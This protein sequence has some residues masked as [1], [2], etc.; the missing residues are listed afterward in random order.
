M[1]QTSGECITDVLTYHVNVGGGAA[2]KPAI[3]AQARYYLQEVA[4]LGMRYATWPY[5]LSSGSVVFSAADSAALPSDFY[6]MG[7]Q[8]TVFI[9]GSIG[10]RLRVVSY[11]E[12]ELLRRNSSNANTTQPTHYCVYGNNS[13]GVPLLQVF[14]NATCTLLVDNYVRKTPE[15]VDR[16]DAPT[17]AAAGTTGSLTGTYYWKVA[18]TTASGDT[19]VGPASTALVLSAGIG[20]L[21][22]IPTSPCHSVT[23]RKIY[24]TKAASPSVFYLAGTISDNTTTTFT[25]NT[26]DVDL[27]AV[28]PAITAAISGMEFWPPDFAERFFVRGMAQG[29]ARNSGDLR[30]PLWYSE[31]EKEIRA[32]WGEMQ[33]QRNEPAAL[34][35]FGTANVGGFRPF[36]D[37]FTS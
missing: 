30:D 11:Q 20:S 34:P 1:Q 8:G 24:R 23:A 15:M 26:A 35:V 32:Y 17:V 12:L 19:E 36:R 27:G 7:T 29:F 3:R 13:T 4:T 14:P 21:T 22:A 5:K 2:L 9:S 31:I 28:A 6:H 25:D 18:Y 16:P 33:G 10:A 37:R